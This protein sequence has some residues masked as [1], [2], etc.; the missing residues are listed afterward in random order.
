M[1]YVRDYLDKFTSDL[2]E[3]VNSYINLSTLDNMKE[4]N[5][6]IR[7][8]HNYV[9]QTLSPEAER[10]QLADTLHE[11]VQK[12]L[13]RLDRD[14]KGFL[15]NEQ[16][17][18][19]RYDS[20]N[21]LNVHETTHQ[22]SSGD[23]NPSTK[24]KPS[25]GERRNGRR[26]RKENSETSESGVDS[27]HT[28]KPQDKPT[29]PHNQNG[30][31]ERT[32]RRERDGSHKD[33]LKRSANSQESPIDPNEPTY[34][35]CNQISFGEMI[36]CDNTECEIEWFHYQCVDLKAPPKDEEAQIEMTHTAL[37]E[38]THVFLISLV[39]F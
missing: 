5:Q 25:R 6:A 21:I 32:H 34:C 9:K 26:N 2:D 3:E 37:S 36:A 10:V 38:Y 18:Q 4:R 33:K 14:W 20:R 30:F 17:E 35:Y 12:H 7:R 22:A 19:T 24:K 13:T 23:E 11:T 28:E 1:D 8:L 15:D 16:A 39:S 31:K 29:R 27:N